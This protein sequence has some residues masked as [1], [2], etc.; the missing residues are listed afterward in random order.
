MRSGERF[1]VPCR[2]RDR[3][4]TRSHAA[5]VAKGKFQI[6]Q[7]VRS[8]LTHLFPSF[9]P[10]STPAALYPSDADSQLERRLA[11]ERARVLG[12]RAG[13]R[14]RRRRQGVHRPP[15]VHESLPP[16]PP[17]SAGRHQEINDEDT[18]ELERREELRS[19]DRCDYD[20]DQTAMAMRYKV[21]RQVRDTM[22]TTIF[23]GQKRI[24]AYC[25]LDRRKK[26]VYVR[27]CCT[28]IVLSIFSP[29][30]ALNLI[31]E[32]VKYK[33]TPAGSLAPSPPRVSRST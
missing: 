7:S 8:K 32:V 27:A 4:E 12:R 5:A 24:V 16:P 25:G 15:S 2:Q 23:S 6:S 11:R 31:A 17:P 3:Q 20:P 13:H 28:P 29:P 33:D 18:N 1:E 21:T 22:S 14:R 30:R 10:S 26:R 19:D 9:L